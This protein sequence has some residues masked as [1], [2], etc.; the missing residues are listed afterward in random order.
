M[1]A[2]QNWKLETSASTHRGQA[3]RSATWQPRKV[4]EA[5]ANELEA[6][7]VQDGINGSRSDM[8]SSYGD[9]QACKAVRLEEVGS[10]RTRQGK[11]EVPLVGLRAPLKRHLGPRFVCDLEYAN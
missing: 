9:S 11:N 4:G 8:G 3:G 7:R 6:I 1:T 5:A 2:S 10:S